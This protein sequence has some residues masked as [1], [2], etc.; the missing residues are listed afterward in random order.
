M[1]TLSVEEA[2]HNYPIHLKGVITY[3]A[4]EYGVTFLQDQTGGI[5]VAN[6]SSDRGLKAGSAVEVDGISSDGDF[7]PTINQPTIRIIGEGRLPP[8]PTRTVEDLLTGLEDSQWIEVK[9]IVHSVALERQLPPEMVTGPAQLVL[10]VASGNSSFKARIR[11]FQPNVDYSYLVDSSVTLRG[12]CGTLF[13]D[14]R[15]LIGVQLF[16]PSLN[17]VTVHNTAPGDPFALPVL[18]I[19]T[20]M[21][22][23]PTRASGHRLHVRATVTMVQRGSW[24]FIQDETGGALVEGIEG[25]HWNTGD[26]VD[27]VGFVKVG[28][29]SPVLLD[30]KIR[31]IGASHIPR[32]IEL[33]AESAFSGDHDAEQVTIAGRVLGQSERLEYHVLALQHG[34]GS[35]TARLEGRE[36][37]N[38]IRSIRDGSWVKA[39]G[40][41]SIE[42]DEYSHPV[43]YHVL[44]RSASDLTVV[45]SPSWWTAERIMALAAVLGGIILAVSLWVTILHRRVE[46]RTA[47]IRATL[48]STADGV[49][50][51]NSQGRIVAS[52]RKFFQMWRLAADSFLAMSED[53]R[54]Q[55][56]AEQLNEPIGFLARLR[57]LHADP[58]A[59]SDDVLEFKDGR[60]FDRHSEP[61][62]VKG[63]SVGCVWGFRDI[64]DRRRTDEELRKA[65]EVAEAASRAKSEFLANMSHEI[66]TPMNGIMG[67]TDLTLETELTS[68]QREGLEMVKA[69]ADSLLT[70]INDI[71]DFS[72][73]EAGKLDL[74]II[75]FNLRDRMEET[76]KLLALSIRDKDVELICDF[77]PDVP[78]TLLGDPIRLRQVVVNLVGNALK[79]TA[80]GEVVLRIAKEAQTGDHV[81]LHF[82]ISDTGIGIPLEKQELIFKAFSQADNSTTRK[83]GGTGLGLS[84]STLLVQMMNGRIWVKSQVGQGSTFHFTG[85]FGVSATP[86]L[87]ETKDLVSLTGIRALIVDDNWINR[88][89]LERMLT[90]WGMHT[91]AVDSA[92]KALG[93]LS[94][95]QDA[96]EPFSLLLTDAHMPDV[97]G[98]TLAEC[99]REN[100]KLAGTA[101]LMLTS[102][103][104]LGDSVRCRELGIGGYL[105]KPVGRAELREAITEV[106]KPASVKS[107][108]S[109]TVTRRTLRMAATGVPL[110]VLLAEDNVVN[111]KIAVKLLQQ[112]GHTV[113]IA[114]NG[115]AA[116]E[117]M[118][119]ERFDLVLMDVQMPELDGLETTRR[120]RVRELK[121][122]GH[123][124]IV[125]MTAFAMAEDR[126]RCLAAGMDGYLSKPIRPA[127][128]LDIIKSMFPVADR[129]A[130]PA[131]RPRSA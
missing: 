39:T 18:P 119:N 94:Q 107:G 122:G 115:R 78:E 22:F 123:V 111:Q 89:V 125:A 79:F 3:S 117:A 108:C 129:G 53:A 17:Q 16:V 44:L 2:R 63:Q 41:W 74:D 29:Y 66:R 25:E 52:N 50:V 47:T 23:S 75:E 65:K 100:P 51:V 124:P 31:R 61:Q 101:M 24:Y 73:I 14:R 34:S 76:V 26:L 112:A 1:R 116:L 104:Q 43:A 88:R 58:E 33:T 6:H 96:A 84:I 91:T 127:E 8:S 86:I 72:K 87:P 130:E 95:A 7:A 9:G 55:A 48:E 71:L 45:R 37:T 80:K 121:Q 36:V 38:S 64:T 67:M 56:M 12:A 5:F 62:W 46:V 126:D 19:N 11:D 77:D 120:I 59:K 42:T 98:F 109:Q 81:T 30:T 97:D 110:R 92:T 10:G 70:I 69:S 103:S 113:M 54:V 82:E 57:E 13:N 4:P 118:D 105:T 60:V 106:L 20:L 35:F 128:L 49:L 15:Q 83:F 99:V 28:N 32:P 68:E 40:V 102:G 114:G 27:V 90:Q 131:E 93:S 85:T 21:Q